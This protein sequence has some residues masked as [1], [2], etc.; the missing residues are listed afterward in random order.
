MLKF[1]F[2]LTIWNADGTPP[3]VYVEDYGLSGE[4]CIALMESFHRD[5][6]QNATPSCEIDNAPDS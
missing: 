5:P 3:D 1:V 2:L 6:I 4:D